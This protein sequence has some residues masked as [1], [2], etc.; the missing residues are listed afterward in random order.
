MNTKGIVGCQGKFAIEWSFAQKFTHA[1]SIHFCCWA[2][3]QRIGD[4]EDE[5]YLHTSRSYME[6][7]LIKESD[8]NIAGSAKISKED[9]FSKIFN[10]FMFSTCS[11]VPPEESPDNLTEKIDLYS[12][13]SSMAEIFLFDDIGQDCFLDKVNIILVSDVKNDIQR[14]IWRNWSTMEVLEVVLP[15]GYVEEICREFLRATNMQVNPR[16]EKA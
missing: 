12:K 9:L 4:F 6:E 7:F 2:N 10:S 11:G 15:L 3:H 1:T 13:A 8:R 14:F 5:V 16:H